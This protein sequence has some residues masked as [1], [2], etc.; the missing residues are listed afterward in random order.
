MTKEIKEMLH[1][2]EMNC[3]HNKCFG[4]VKLDEEDCKLLLNYI[5]NLQQE[6]KAKTIQIETLNEILNYENIRNDKLQQENETL[7][8]KLEI[9]KTCGFCPYYDYKSRCEKAIEYIKENYL[10]STIN[11]QDDKYKLIN[12]L[13]GSDV[14]ETNS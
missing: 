5:T 2:I 6:N 9:G 13:N 14:N 11:Y 1:C 10:T 12:I 3:K 7:K 8:A 4:G